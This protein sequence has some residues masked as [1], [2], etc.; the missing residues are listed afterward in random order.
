MKLNPINY[1]SQYNNNTEYSKFKKSNSPSFGNLAVGLASFI[2]KNGFL[3][4]FLAVDTTGMMGPR[5]VQGYTRNMKELGHLNYKAGHEETIRELLSGPAFFYVP[6]IVLSLA[7]AIKGKVAKVDTKTLGEFKAVMQNTAVDMKNAIATKTNFVKS[8]V[9]N[10][11]K[12]YEHGQNLVEE[13]AEL[14]HKNATEKFKFTDKI[15]NLFKNEAEKVPTAS[16][17][18]EKAV[19]LMTKLNKENAKNL[20]NASAIELNGKK[21]NISDLFD[22]MKNY[23]DDFTQ[24]AEK[25]TQDKE[26]FIEKFHNKARDLRYAAN[27]LAVSALSAFLVII[28][29]LYQ[30]GKKFPGKDGLNT[31]ETNTV[32]NTNTAPQKEQEAV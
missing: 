30:T 12:D 15:A 8:V 19:E 1:T 16:S 2:E 9:K 18:R 29:K 13:I 28:P 20:D 22:D 6:L 3:G 14:M 23:L 21:F 26:T 11:F 32:A 24:K 27:I 31:G 25:S 4:E 17:Y 5:A 10:S 7:S